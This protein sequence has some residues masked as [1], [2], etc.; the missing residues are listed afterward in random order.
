MKTVKSHRFRVFILAACILVLSTAVL[1]ISVNMTMGAEEDRT[2]EEAA[3]NAAPT[4][5]APVNAAPANPGPNEIEEAAEPAPSQSAE[6]RVDAMTISP[7]PAS[8]DSPMETAA[9]TPTPAPTPVTV[10]SPA[11]QVQKLIAKD[12][13]V[14]ACLKVAADIFGLTVDPGSVTANFSPSEEIKDEK[15]NIVNTTHDTWIIEGPGFYCSIDAATNAITIFYD[16]NTEYRGSSIKES[17]FKEIGN[18]SA[19]DG[20]AVYLHNSPDN[21]YIK[22]AEKLVNERLANGRKI[23]DIMIDGVQFVWDDSSEDECTPDATGTIQV[24]C[25]VLM[26]KGPNYTLSFWGTDEIVLK[27]FT[28]HPTQHACLWGY[29]YEEDAA[30]YPPV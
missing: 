15:G 20:G 23:S 10:Q 11:P 17:Q 3:L 5:A 13:A 22:A 8:I 12:Q 29:F 30:K 27:I 16:T 7:H 28:S 18:I 1:I 9:P 21:A 14:E 6:G 26:E 19:P 4:N 2:I 25:H 24:D